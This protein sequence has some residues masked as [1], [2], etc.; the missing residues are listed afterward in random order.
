MRRIS[1]TRRSNSAQPRR[2]GSGM[3]LFTAG[4]HPVEASGSRLQRIEPGGR[5]VDLGQFAES[6]RER[7]VAPIKVGKRRGTKPQVR[8][9]FY[10]IA[11]GRRVPRM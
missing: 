3:M 6:P 4:S 10:G 8:R 9:Y 7:C 5:L 2:P 11:A 1:P